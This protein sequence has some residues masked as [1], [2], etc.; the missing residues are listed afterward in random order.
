M[1]IDFANNKN[2]IYYVRLYGYRLRA[3]VVLN[4]TNK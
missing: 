3:W 1:I 2:E 4:E